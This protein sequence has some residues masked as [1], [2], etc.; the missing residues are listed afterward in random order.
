MWAD[1]VLVFEQAH[2]ARLLFWGGASVLTGVALWAFLRVKRLD[3]PLL[4]HFAIQ[5]GAWGAIDALLALAARPGLALRDYDG[6]TSLDRFLWFNC[7]LDV[8]YVAV[9][10]AHHT[11]RDQEGFEMAISQADEVRECHN[12]T[13]AFEY[14]L[15][16]E[17]ADLAGY[18][19][20]HTEVLGVLPQVSSITTY[21]VMGS[22]RDDR[23]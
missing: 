18:K 9:G 4:R 17:A 2:L 10:L 1:Q 7:G 6:V 16:I 22:P 8:A 13:G 11:K 5:T 20:F 3:L 15:R 23:A 12:V 14:I 21:V 19:H